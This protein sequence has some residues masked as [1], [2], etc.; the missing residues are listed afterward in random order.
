MSK[1]PQDIL[2]AANEKYK[3]LALSHAVYIQGRLDER[4]LHKSEAVEFLKWMG[5]QEL[6]PHILKVKADEFYQLF[7]TEKN[8]KK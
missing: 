2:D 3:G 7:L 5:G 1:I 4:N 8:K 6:M